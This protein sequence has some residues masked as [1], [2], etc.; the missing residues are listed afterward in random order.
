MNFVNISVALPE[1]LDNL[2]YWIFTL[3]GHQG[4][5]GTF[6]QTI[7]FSV[8]SRCS[9]IS[10]SKV[11]RLFNV[12]WKSS[13]I[14]RRN[15]FHFYNQYISELFLLFLSFSIPKF[16]NLSLFFPLYLL[17]LSILQILLSTFSSPSVLHLGSTR[18]ALDPSYIL[19]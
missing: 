11:I 5:S 16:R 3:A 17:L 2:H 15:H 1:S 9:A 14:Q 19:I 4:Y 13:H 18:S 7:C 12:I 6:A 10:I 8:Y